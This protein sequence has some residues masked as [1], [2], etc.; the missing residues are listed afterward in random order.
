VHPT[1]G[2]CATPDKF[3]SSLC[4][5]HPCASQ[6]LTGAHKPTPMPPLAAGV[7]ASF[8]A[9]TPLQARTSMAARDCQ[10]PCSA[11][12]GNVRVARCCRLPPACAL[13]APVLPISL[14]PPS[15][16]QRAT[17]TGL[18]FYRMQCPCCA[19]GRRRCGRIEQRRSGG[20][21]GGLSGRPAQQAMQQLTA[22]SAV[23]RW[24]SASA[25]SWWLCL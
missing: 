21:N 11:S 18:T 5:L 12:S 13:A 14:Q 4:S 2:V 22:K 24:L 23:Q 7:A 20:S 8:A 15:Q 1:G 17:R 10:P 9:I 6:P 25:A 3:S 19:C 16:Q